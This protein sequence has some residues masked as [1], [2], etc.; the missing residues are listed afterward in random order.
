MKFCTSIPV[1]DIRQRTHP[2]THKKCKIRAILHEN[3][4]NF[5]NQEIIWDLRPENLQNQPRNT[6]IVT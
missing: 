5:A 6:Q 4:T 2:T 1:Q 3:V